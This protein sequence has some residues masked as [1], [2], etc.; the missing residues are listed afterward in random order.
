MSRVLKTRNDQITQT[1]DQ[2]IGWSKG[3]DIVGYPY[4]IDDITA[5][6]DGKV[7]K[8]IN[9][10]TKFDHSLDNEGM[11]YGN[12]VMIQ[13]NNKDVTL[14][15]HLEYV[16]VKVGDNVK[17]GQIIGKMGDT[18]NSHGGHLHLEHRVYSNL[19]IN[20]LH[21]TN[22]FKWLNPVYILDKDFNTK[23]IKNIETYN[24]GYYR[25]RKNWEDGY[26]KTNQVGAYKILDNAIKKANELIGYSVFN[27]K[28]ELV[29]EKIKEN[30]D[31]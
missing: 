14:Y 3:V 31:I 4:C 12:Y 21:D 5:H 16:L 11:G 23:D 28:G 2:H 7:I 18:G 26:S 17:A 29:W 6:S 19:N 24:D 10:K 13:H 25:V 9:Y 22:S 27:D 20:N 30:K 1:F 15:A 8:V